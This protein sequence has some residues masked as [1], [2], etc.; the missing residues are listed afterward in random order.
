MS[1]RWESCFWDLTFENIM[2]Y[3]FNKM[4]LKK[5]SFWDKELLGYARFWV[6]QIFEVKK[7]KCCR[8]FCKFHKHVKVSV[9]W[10]L[11]LSVVGGAKY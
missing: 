7:H 8:F 4:N 3:P 2:K 6:K 1:K 10:K 11:I 5:I 9:E